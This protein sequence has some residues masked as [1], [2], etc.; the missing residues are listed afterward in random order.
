MTEEQHK[1]AL[2]IKERIN[3]IEFLIDF[4]VKITENPGEDCKAWLREAGV[5]VHPKEARILQA[6]IDCL[7]EAL[8]KE[9][10]RLN[11]EF[12]RL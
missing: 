1:R 4:L 8:E 3:H 7:R 11:Q 9:K 5:I 6:D 10:I 12:N 2:Q